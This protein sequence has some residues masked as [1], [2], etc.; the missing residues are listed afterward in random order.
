MDSD[1]KMPSQ[2]EEIFVYKEINNLPLKGR[3]LEFG[4]GDDIF[5][6]RMS[7]LGY[8]VTAI[9]L[10]KRKRL[11]NFNFIQSDFLYTDLPENYFD[12]VYSLSSFEHIGLEQDGILSEDDIL[13]KIN[14]ITKKIKL[15]L[16]YNGI[17]LVTIPFGNY[18]YY[19]V[20]KDGWSYEKRHDSLWGVKVYDIKDIYEIFKDFSILKK[21]FYLRIDSD[22]INKNS[23]ILIDHEKCY[24]RKEQTDSIVCLKLINN[25]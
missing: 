23:W 15:I 14:L 21:E 6:N 17:F 19:Y 9:D 12:A 8:E 25:K 18:R 16:K 3:L 24:F 20:G 1:N 4:C 10:F 11:T 2:I 7:D 22:Y 13:Y 5:P